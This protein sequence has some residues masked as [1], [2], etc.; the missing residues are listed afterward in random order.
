MLNLIYVDDTHRTCLFTATPALIVLDGV[1]PP[2]VI[3]TRPLFKPRP[4]FGKKYTVYI[5][6]C[7][8]F[9][10]FMSPHGA[11]QDV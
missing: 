7:V 4:L 5:T 8:D 6:K 2:A 9:N 1:E 10:T 3:Q 11:L